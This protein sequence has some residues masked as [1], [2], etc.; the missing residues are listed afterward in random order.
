MPCNTCRSGNG[1]GPVRLAGRT[2][3]NGPIRA[4][5]SSDTTHGA[6]TPRSS[7]TKIINLLGALIRVLPV[8][9]PEKPGAPEAKEIRAA[10]RMWGYNPPQRDSGSMPIEVGRV[11]EWLSRHTLPVETVHNADTMRALQR[12]V[13]RRLDGEPYAPT[14][15][16]RT[17]S[18]LS[19]CLDYAVERDILGSNPLAGVKWSQMPKGKRKVDKRAVPN[20]VQARTMLSTI[21]ETARSGERLE[22]FFA[23]MY[24]AAMRPEEAADLRKE[25]LSL[26][27]ATHDPV[28]GERK[29]DW[30]TI[31]LEG[32]RPYIDARWT[33]RGTVGEQRPLKSRAAGD[34]RPV[35]CPPELTA[36]LWR[37]IERHGCG[38][39][40]RLFTGERGGP[41]SKVTYMKVWRAARTSALTKEAEAGPLLRRPYD[42]RHAAVSTWLAA[43]VPA[44]TVALWAGQSVSVL[45]EVYASFLDGG[46]RTAKRRIEEALG[47]W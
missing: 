41:I 13:T 19:N 29:Y 43:G 39:D 24:F 46:E 33:D 31:Y 16:R 37:H 20:P 45:L 34:V 25:N 7:Q 15:A 3:N 26:P 8:F 42:L 12:S 32:A 4:H 30:G 22:A 11:L 10:A 36:I 1:F 40:G 27:A 44:A 5:N 21:A 17:R 14:V 28:S 18:V 47:G 35:P 6:A 23:L 2:G 9:V 38:T